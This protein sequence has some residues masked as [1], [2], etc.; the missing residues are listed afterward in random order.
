MSGKLTV[1]PEGLA[2]QIQD[3]TR[4]RNEIRESMD[5]INAEYDLLA[6]YMKGDAATARA[7]FQQT[8]D[9]LL[10]KTSESIQQLEKVSH[11]FGEDTVGIDHSIGRRVNGA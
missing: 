9:M 8:A 2:A 11:Q 10:Q 3:M 5:R 4:I 1:Q 6:D 7:D